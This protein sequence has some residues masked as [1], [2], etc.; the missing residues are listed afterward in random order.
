MRFNKCQDCQMIYLSPRMSEEQARKFYKEEYVESL[1]SE[2]RRKQAE[3]LYKLIM[4]ETVTSHLN[5]GK[6]D[7]EMAQVFDL[8]EA[9]G[10]AASNK[11]FDLITC[12]QVLQRIN[13]PVKFVE[14]MLKYLNPDGSLW[15]EVPN[16]D[17]RFE[18]VPWH[19]MMFT[20]DT[21]AYTIKKAGGKINRLFAYQ[22]YRPENK[23]YYLMAEV[24]K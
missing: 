15:I 21:L 20:E 9:P 16:C 7:E 3:A 12:I 6:Y 8:V 4:K 23:P 1:D 18:P 22:G 5:I 17:Y 24:K 10:Q 2:S 14:D 11:K 19:V 13:Y